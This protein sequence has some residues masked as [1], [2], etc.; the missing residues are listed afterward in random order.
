M[1]RLKWYLSHTD[2]AAAFEHHLEMARSPLGSC[3]YP[4]P[5]VEYVR[6]VETDTFRHYYPRC[7][8]VHRCRNY[9]GCCPDGTVC[10]PK[11]DNGIR[12]FT[13]AFLVRENE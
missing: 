13:K 2:R 4:L 6:S 12:I 9:T 3:R 10:G 7:T 5:E 11:K 1:S 8:V